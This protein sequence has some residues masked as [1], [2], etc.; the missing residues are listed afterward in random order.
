MSLLG[1]KIFRSYHPIPWQD[2]ISQPIALY[3]MGMNFST[4]VE[5]FDTEIGRLVPGCESYYSGK[6]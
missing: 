3:N 4:G 1:V 5:S 6:N 2:S